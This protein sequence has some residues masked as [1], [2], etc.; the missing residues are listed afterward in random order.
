MKIDSL[1]L[2]T[3]WIFVTFEQSIENNFRM[4]KHGDIIII[5]DDEDDQFLMK[6]AFESWDYVNESK[7]FS[8][9]AIVIE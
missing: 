9:G 6:K 5:E 1:V 3:G 8:N 4:N 7:Y 2:A